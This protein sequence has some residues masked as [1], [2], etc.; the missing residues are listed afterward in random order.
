MNNKATI[1]Q[2]FMIAVFILIGWTGQSHAQEIVS[3]VHVKQW[4]EQHFA[5]GKTPPFSFLYGGKKSADFIRNWQYKSEQLASDKATVE[6]FLYTYTDKGS[7]LAVRCT[8]TCYTDFPAVDWV[9]SFTNASGKN[10]PLIEQIEV[11]N[12]TFT[13][14]GD[15]KYI[16]H[17]N[18]GSNYGKDDFLPIDEEIPVG[19]TVKI[20]QTRGRSSDMSALP[21][22]NIEMPGSRGI[23][24]AIGWTGSWYADVSP[25]GRES[26]SLKSGMGTIR[27]TLY[28]KES[29]RTPRI[30]LLFWNGE[31]RMTGHNR[32]RQLV[33]EHYSPKI[34]GKP[35]EY[36]LSGG[37]FGHHP[38][39]GDLVCGTLRS[40]F[41]LA[42]IERHRQFDIVPD[43][44][45]LDA[46]W[47]RLD[48]EGEDGTWLHN[49]GNWTIDPVRFPDGLRPIADASHAAG[50]KFLVWFE[51]ERVRPHSEIG[52]AHPEWLL[53]VP[54]RESRVMNL[55]NPEALHWLTEHVTD[56]IKK[57]GIDYYRQDCNIDPLLYWNLND[58]PNRIGMTQIKHIEGLYAFWDSLLVR[59][60]NIIIDNCA[61]GGR[62]LDIETNLR[63]ASFWSSD[64][65]FDEPNGHQCHTYGLN[66][67]LPVHG[68]GVYSTDRYM[69]RSS[70]GATMVMDWSVTGRDSEPVEAI[71]RR[72]KDFKELRP[73][74]YGDFYPLTDTKKFTGDDV[75]LAYQMNRP[76]EG[77][78]FILAFR[79][80]DNMDESIHIQPEG[81]EKDALY[82]LFYEDYGIRLN[83][84]GAELMKGFDITIPV[85]GASLMIRYG[86][87]K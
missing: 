54:N 60:P 42:L 81:L 76:K 69:F 49:I 3:P 37:G 2:K 25:T 79:R 59:F 56:F 45:W 5:R 46:G 48:I 19:K 36:P 1:R 43:V 39:A 32:F 61:S 31:N 22:F 20:E 33:I 82:E 28:P 29:M 23:V 72:M 6:K 11:I 57:E 41:A 58:Q 73:Y 26:L 44:F 78:G 71:Q 15:G 4:V 18:R 51:P 64:Y 53:V 87:V 34:N 13:S 47:Y 67:Y 80:Q 62:R 68:T 24:A 8:V 55:G 86:K 7:G 9:L 10:T 38:K 16:L 35:I 66:F 85:P 77:D 52:L 70:L 84:P 50:A 75:W 63:S 17:R 30:C 40:D 27:T 83:R 12:Q 14:N 74:F 65:K 21:F